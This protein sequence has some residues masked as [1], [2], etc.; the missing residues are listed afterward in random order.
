MTYDW[1]GNIRELENTLKRALVLC[2]GRVLLP[3]HF[4]KFAEGVSYSSVLE[5]AT[6]EGQLRILL[7]EWVSQN[8]DSE[9]SESELL[10]QDTRDFREATVR[11]CS[12]ANR[13]ESEQSGGYFWESIEIRCTPK[14]MNTVSS[15][16]PHQNVSVIA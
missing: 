6:L 8:L 3:E 9:Q 7:N 2:T 1:P 5:G 14:W 11:D 4:P 10:F 16:K 13:L 12:E 15:T